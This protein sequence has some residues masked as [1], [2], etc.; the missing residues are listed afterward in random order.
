MYVSTNGITFKSIDGI[1]GLAQ[2]GV[3]AVFY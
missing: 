2:D 3:T 1:D